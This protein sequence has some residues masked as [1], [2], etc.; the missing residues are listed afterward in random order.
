MRSCKPS[1]SV[2]S[3]ITL[4]ANSPL[5]SHSN[6]AKKRKRQAEFRSRELQAAQEG[7]R[8]SREE[9]Q[10]ADPEGRYP[11]QIVG[12]ETAESQEGEQGTLH[13]HAT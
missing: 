9:P 8:R 4:N 5:R 11:H 2:V 3:F 6:Q 10:G 1:L 7:Q 12:Q 13:A